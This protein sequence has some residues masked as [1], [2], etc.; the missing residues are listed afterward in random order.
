MHNEF[1]NQP[2]VEWAKRK[3]PAPLEIKLLFGSQWM[4]LLI[5]LLLFSVPLLIVAALVFLKVQGRFEAN[6]W[7]ISLCGIVMLLPPLLII[8]VSLLTRQKIARSLDSDGVSASLGRKYLW[9]DLYY[10]D[11]VSKITRVAGVTR[12]T[13]DNQLELVFADGKAIIPP[14]I[15]NRIGVWNLINSIPVQV[16]DD[17]K[18]REPR[19]AADISE[20]KG[21]P[22]FDAIVK[23][24]QEL[25]A[26][27]DPNK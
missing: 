27:D 2:V 6:W 11:H 7:G 5:Y 26:K 18:I 3:L 15:D 13:A 1:Y 12:K 19:V 20:N 14:L 23:A 10:V 4:R 25:K 24:M 22:S 21:A 8:L 9:R 17:G 16:R